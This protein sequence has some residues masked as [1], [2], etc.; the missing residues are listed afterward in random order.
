MFF[1]NLSRRFLLFLFGWEGAHAHSFSVYANAHLYASRPGTLN[2]R[3]SGRAPPIPD[4]FSGDDYEWES[5]LPH[6]PEIE[7]MSYGKRDWGYVD[8]SE[9][10]YKDVVE[11]QEF[12][13]GE[14]WNVKRKYNA[15]GGDYGNEKIAVVWKYD[16]GGEC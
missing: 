6:E 3:K 15:S 5:T 8:R 9:R 14:V 16:F 2:L 4:W 1:S 10:D 12:T 13:L 7:V 11:D